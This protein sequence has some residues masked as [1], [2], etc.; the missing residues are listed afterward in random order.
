MSLL[1]IKDGALMLIKP[2]FSAVSR[3]HQ[4]VLRRSLQRVLVVAP[5][6]V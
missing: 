1:R 4:L 3:Q 2:A 5:A 6:C